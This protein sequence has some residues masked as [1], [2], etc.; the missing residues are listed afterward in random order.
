MHVPF[1][2]DPSAGPAMDGSAASGSSAANVAAPSTREQCGALLVRT[3]DWLE[4]AVPQAPELNGLVPLVTRAVDLYSRGDYA[5]C[6]QLAC[7]V[8]QAIALAR[9]TVASLPAW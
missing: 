7:G 8:Q 6:L 4:R 2:S 3:H 5:G 9:A 1:A